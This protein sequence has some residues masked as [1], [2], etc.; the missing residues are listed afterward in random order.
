MRQVR[1][2][3]SWYG[4]GPSGAVVIVVVCGARCTCGT[5]TLGVPQA[6]HEYTDRCASVPARSAS[7]SAAGVTWDLVTSNAPWAGRS[8]H[9]TVIDAAGTMYVISGY[10]GSAG[11]LNDVWVSADKGA[12]RTQGLHVWHTRASEGYSTGYSRGHSR[13]VNMHIF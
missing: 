8:G 10:G 11:F 3:C 1:Y 9:T 6:L 13:N 4:T 2:V 7:P 5:A 12:N